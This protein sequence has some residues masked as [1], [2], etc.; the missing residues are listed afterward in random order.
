MLA[1]M[2]APLRAGE[3]APP[4][5]G[6]VA[7][8][9][10][11]IPLGAET[12]AG[13]SRHLETLARSVKTEAPAE[14]RGVAQMLA[15]AL[16]L[17]PANGSAR[18]LILAYQNNRR[19]PGPDPG[20][21]EKIRSRI[22]QQIAWLETPEAGSH[23]QALAACLKDVMVISDP[24]H[25]RAAAL[26]EAGEKGVW[27]GWIPPVS[28]YEPVV[29]AEKTKAPDVEPDPK[30]AAETSNLL[31]LA[32]VDAL[33]WQRVGSGNKATWMLR[34]APLRMSVSK[35][36]GE[37]GDSGDQ[38]LAGEAPPF[39]L[40]IGSGEGGFGLNA[41][42]ATLRNTLMRQQE[43]LPRGVRVTI[44]SKEF[45]QSLESHKRQTVSAAAAVL[46]SAALTGREP[47]GLIIGQ[48]D[49]NG[50]FKLPNGFWDQIRALGK[51]SG[52]RLV[53]PAEAGTWLPSLLALEKPG[54]FMDYEVLLAADFKQLLE[55]SAKKPEGAVSSA[56]AK[57][58]EIREKAG[59]Q[60]VRQYIGNSFVK[61]RLMAV[62]QDAPMHFSAKMLLVQAAGN[63]PT[64]VL[65]PVLAAE[66]RRALEP[67][68]WIIEMPEYQNEI[69]ADK[70]IGETYDLC[71]S[72]V[73]GLQRYAEKNDLPLVEQ[74]REVLICLRNLDRATRA[75]GESYI[76]SENIRSARNVL[77]RNARLFDE[78]LT[79]EI[80]GPPAGGAR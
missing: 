14:R 10:D 68:G 59:S 55:L 19:P 56:A 9:R 34:P 43:T 8:R 18:E 12:M 7:F 15:L 23:G 44:S 36:T 3:F 41:M 76:V 57:F 17:D 54:F 64:T 28:A 20:Q 47:E 16:A 39:S 67:M 11:L 53:L 37:T 29:L 45:L 62:L 66:I 73:D 72:Q 31:E 33:L 63:R 46:A 61:Q 80:E 60:D 42:A 22:W 78:Q 35:V 58:R 4:A 69:P 25:P 21:L 49:E 24:D 26:R 75:R 38:A 52:R 32:E 50:A 65:R 13:L 79:V 2:A 27:A 77:R 5:E 48:V 6:P 51:G 30:P 1:G 70:K 71:R 74:A 40:V